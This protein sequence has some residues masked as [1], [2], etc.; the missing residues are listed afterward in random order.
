V[1]AVAELA[2]LIV[3]PALVFGLGAY[4]VARARREALT[5]F[6][7][8]SSFFFGVVLVV[9]SFALAGGALSYLTAS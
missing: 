1:G 6:T 3:L 8:Y 2:V 4:L 7:A 5:R 9:L